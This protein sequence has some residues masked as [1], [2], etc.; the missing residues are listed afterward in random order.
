MI[1]F[2]I[3]PS[4]G[5]AAGF[6]GSLNLSG[7]IS[8]TCFVTKAAILLNGEIIANLKLNITIS[9][10]E[11]IIVN[12]I[13]NQL[14]IVKIDIVGAGINHKNKRIE[15]KS[16]DGSADNPLTGRG[17]P[18]FENGTNLRDKASGIVNKGK[19]KNSKETNGDD[20]GKNEFGNR[21]FVL[22]VP[23]AASLHQV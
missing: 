6:S 20:G 10:G 23:F 14:G 7:N 9:A 8:L 13:P 17:N 3:A 4:T 5:E 1:V 15:I 2:L 18:S 19:K 12:A 21:V 16:R 11:K 22:K